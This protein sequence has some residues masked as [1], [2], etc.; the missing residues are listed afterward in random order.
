MDG[1]TSSQASPLF[2]VSCE[3][4]TIKKAEHER[5]DT[6][7]LWCWRRLLRVPW[8]S[9]RL[10][11]SIPKEI[12]PEYYWKGWCWSWSSNTLA[13]WYKELTHWKRPWW[14]ERLKARGEWGDRGWEGWM[15]S[16][17]QWT[18]NLN[19]LHEIVKDRE[20]W[21]AVVHAFP[22]SWTQLS[23]WTTAAAT[24][25]KIYLIVLYSSDVGLNIPSLSRLQYP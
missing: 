25:T 2:H 18:W 16:L 20:A 17:I 23:D 13:I 8:T 6:F 10:N 5:I 15:V 19:K 14:W 1:F 3:S 24:T 22:K 7:E 9:R 4:W 11:H 21:C 12:N